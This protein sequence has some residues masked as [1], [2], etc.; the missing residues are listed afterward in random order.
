M[1]STLA[2][3]QKL[4]NL[5]NRLHWIYILLLV[6]NSLGGR[7]TDTRIHKLWTKQLQETRLT[8]ACGY[9]MP[10]LKHYKPLL[11]MHSFHLNL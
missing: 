6:I 4:Y 11:V 7:H 3:T 10:D 8:P 2:P 9:S 5:F 1:I